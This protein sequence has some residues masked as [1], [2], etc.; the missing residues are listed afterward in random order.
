MRKGE[1]GGEDAVTQNI[2]EHVDGAL[3][4]FTFSQ[5]QKLMAM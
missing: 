3:F 2:V 5:T 4:G 1:E